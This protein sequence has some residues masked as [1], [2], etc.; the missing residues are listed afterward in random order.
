MHTKL[1][2][3][4]YALK[5]KIYDARTNN[6]NP[7]NRLDKQVLSDHQKELARLLDIERSFPCEPELDSQAQK[8]PNQ[9]SPVHS[10][11]KNGN[12]NP[13]IK[14]AQQS[15]NVAQTPRPRRFSISINRLARNNRFKRIIKIVI[16]PIQIR[17]GLCF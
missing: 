12:Q 9:L 7:E 16:G 3:E 15:S 13:E 17:I 6:Q 11:V 2:K 4:G 5:G 8:P 1:L 10:T 14:N